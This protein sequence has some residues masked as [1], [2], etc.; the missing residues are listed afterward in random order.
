MVWGCEWTV[1]NNR[2]GITQSVKV[3]VHLLKAP[4]ADKLEGAARWLAVDTRPRHTV[5]PLVARRVAGGG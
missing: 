2:R 4:T 1:D 3:S 5:R